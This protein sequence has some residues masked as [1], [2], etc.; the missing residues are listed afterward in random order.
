MGTS[1]NI[2]DNNAFRTTREYFTYLLL[3]MKFSMNGRQ[4]M[5]HDHDNNYA[6]NEIKVQN[7]C[8]TKVV[9]KI[10]FF[11]IGCTLFPSRLTYISA[12]LFLSTSFYS[13]RYSVGNG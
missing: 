9:A 10:I 1:Y 8:L 13:C 2:E 6:E 7:N 3:V 4:G 5:S 11:F 12:E